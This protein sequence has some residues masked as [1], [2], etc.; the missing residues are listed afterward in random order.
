MLRLLVLEIVVML[1]VDTLEADK[2]MECENIAAVEFVLVVDRRMD[3]T[4][5]TSTNLY[6]SLY[7]VLCRNLDPILSRI[8][9]SDSRI[10]E[11][12]NQH[13]NRLLFQSW[14]LSPKV[15]FYLLLAFFI[16]PLFCAYAHIQLC[17]NAQKYINVP[18]NIKITDRK[19]WEIKSV[20]T[21]EDIRKRLELLEKERET[22]GP[23]IEQKNIARK[24]VQ[25]A[26]QWVL[27]ETDSLLTY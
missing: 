24:A 4:E 16:S 20:R 1:L 5:D 13:N 10:L 2:H 17:E 14:V 3:S 18:L 6:Q 23:F 11:Q 25:Q 21:E 12:D 7:R 26:L 27:E 8:Q 19:T 9:V 15:L 22:E